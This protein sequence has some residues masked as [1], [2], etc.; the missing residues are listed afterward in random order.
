MSK[1]KATDVPACPKIVT[2]AARAEWQRVVKILSTE[3]TIRQLD[4]ATL[5]AYC[6]AWARLIHAE[7]KI[8]E[9]GGD[10]VKSPNG[11][12]IMNP[13]LSIVNTAAKQMRAAMRDLG[14]SPASRRR[15]RKPEPVTR[16]LS[17]LQPSKEC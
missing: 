2:G 16:G 11:Y 5:A 12:P 8:V 3:G 17:I 7:A 15:K 1:P 13:W 9:S 14:L 4:L 10:V 6:L